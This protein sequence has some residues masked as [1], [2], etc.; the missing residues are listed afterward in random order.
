M[1]LT[2]DALRQAGSDGDVTTIRAAVI[3][4]VFATRHRVSPLGRYS[5]DKNGDTTLR[6]YDGYKV[7]RDG[8]LR[9]DRVLRTG[10]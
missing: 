7:G 9:F 8:Y 1:R 4:T 10:G 6:T 3:R 5:I 2:L